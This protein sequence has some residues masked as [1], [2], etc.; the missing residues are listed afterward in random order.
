MLSELQPQSIQIQMVNDLLLI[1]LNNIEKET[2]YV[3]KNREEKIVRKGK[4][5][6]NKVQLNFIHLPSGHYKLKLNHDDDVITCEF[7]KQES[8]YIFYGSNVGQAT[9]I[10]SDFISRYL[11]VK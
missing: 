11:T 6:R 8:D 10:A 9:K 1:E 2:E 7:E 5:M 4:F 3:L